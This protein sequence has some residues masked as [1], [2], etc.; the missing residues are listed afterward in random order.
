ML[1]QHQHQHSYWWSHGHGQ[2][3]ALNINWTYCWQYLIISCT[4]HDAIAFT[5]SVEMSQLSCWCWAGKPQS[6]QLRTTHYKSSWQPD[7]GQSGGNHLPSPSPPP[8]DNNSSTLFHFRNKDNFQFYYSLR[9]FVWIR[10][11]NGFVI[12]PIWRIFCE[13]HF[14]EMSRQ[15]ASQTEKEMIERK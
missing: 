2:N 8:L 3:V 15:S 12:A 11:G 14:P 5:I 1:L 7:T 6:C 13:I 4:F 9:S 10:D